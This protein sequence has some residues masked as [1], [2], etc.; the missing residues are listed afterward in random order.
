MLK[1]K[2]KHFGIELGSQDYS[3]YCLYRNTNMGNSCQNLLTECNSEH[4]HIHTHS[5]PTR[6]YGDGIH[7]LGCLR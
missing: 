6:F 5:P 3:C 2:N 4:T 1:K 7:H